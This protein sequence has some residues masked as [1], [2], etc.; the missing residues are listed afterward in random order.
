MA[1]LPAFVVGG[2]ERSSMTV[3][4]AM[5]RGVDLL[6][7]GTTLQEAATRMAADDVGALLI[8]R[9]GRLEGI[10][11]DR[12]ILIRAVVE[13]RDVARTTVGEV[14]SGDLIVCHE[15]D[16]AADAFAKMRDGQIRRMPVL[17]AEERLAGIV[18]LSDLARHGLQPGPELL[19]RLAE[20]HRA[21]EATDADDDMVRHSVT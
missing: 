3:G 20:P 5:T 10:V 15:G 7:P 16:D 13:G 8:G 17:D 9:D 19:R 1:A 2:G 11:T 21:P 4:E 6:D 12:D 14:M 18:T